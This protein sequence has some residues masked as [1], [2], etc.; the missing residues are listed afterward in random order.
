MNDSSDFARLRLSRRRLL[1][2]F[3]LTG[4]GVGLGVLAACT[5]SAPPGRAYR[6]AGRPCCR[7]ADDCTGRRRR[8]A[9]RG[10]GSSQASCDHGPSRT[11]GYDG[12]N[13]CTCRR[14][15]WRSAQARAAQSDLHRHAGR[16]QRP[17]PRLR[18]FQH[19]HGGRFSQ[20]LAC[21]RA[22]DDG[23]AADHVRRAHRRYENWLAEDW[24]YNADF[25]EPR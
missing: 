8:R 19:P 9:Y 15:R 24:K 20:R 13:D 23:R 14:R 17:E 16:Q 1:T 25:T 12:P 21:R 10:P 11:S 4:L 5:P 6:G 22:S 18:Q 2:G 7:C 3:G